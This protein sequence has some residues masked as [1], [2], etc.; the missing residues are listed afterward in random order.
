MRRSSGRSPRRTQNRKAVAATPMQAVTGLTWG[1]PRT[2]D[3]IICG[4]VWPPA[5]MPRT[6]P[7]W[8]VAIRMPDAVM[9]PA[10]TGCDRKFA[11]KP[12]FSTPIT[13]RIAPDSPASVSA[14]AA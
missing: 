9:K 3:A 2:S 1:R 10:I 7:S 11:R 8:L 13:T 4:R 5:P 12:S 6:W 14:A